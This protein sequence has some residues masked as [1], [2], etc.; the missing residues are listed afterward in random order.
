MDFIDR[1]TRSWS[2]A[3]ASTRVLNEDGELLLL[4]ILSGI[5]S[6]ALCGGLVWLASTNG[7]FEAVQEGATF[8]AWN[9]FY[10]WLFVFYLVQ[11]FVITFFNTALVGAALERLDGGDPTVRSALGLALRR[12]G[13]IFGY[14]VASATVGIVLRIIAD[15]L[16]WVGQLIGGGLAIAWSVV[17]FLVVP[18]IAAEGLGPIPAIERSAR[19]LG[20]TWGE[21]IIGNV[22]ISLV[23]SILSGI[24]AFA[25]GGAVLL[26]QGGNM[27][28][29]MP[30]LVGA[31]FVLL[32]IVVFST[33]LSAV[34]SAAVYYYAVTGRTPGGFDGDL[35]R[36]AFTEKPA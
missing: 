30:L 13:P 9:G 14:A 25:V 18:V 2:L 7:T 29:G 23:F 36:R 27:V 20:K 22:G 6:F 1:V 32:G 15:R 10:V 17:T 3:K 12:I 11:Y 31:V 34:Y 24:A 19:L 4:P 33:A 16:G 5:V 8:E 21:N 28:A 26:V 35:V